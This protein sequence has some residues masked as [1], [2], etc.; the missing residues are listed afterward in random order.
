MKLDI[1]HLGRSLALN[2]KLMTA[3]VTLNGRSVDGCVYADDAT[4]VIKRFARDPKTGRYK[5]NRTR[6]NGD[7]IAVETCYGSVRIT[8]KENPDD[9]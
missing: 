2:Q 5:I 3:Q 6:Q 4:G 1:N 7:C 8:F 9:Q